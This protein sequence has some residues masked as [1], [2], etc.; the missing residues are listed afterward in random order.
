MPAMARAGPGRAGLG[1]AGLGWAEAEAGSLDSHQGLPL[2]AEARLLE[3]SLLPSGAHTGKKLERG[4]KT[5]Q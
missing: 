2:R 5:R 4:A 1:R 3:P